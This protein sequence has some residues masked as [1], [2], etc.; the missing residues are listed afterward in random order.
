M[1]LNDTLKVKES[2]RFKDQTDELLTYFHSLTMEELSLA[3]DLKSSQLTNQVYS[4]YHSFNIR[5]HPIF[6]YQGQSFKQLDFAAY[7]DKEYA[8]VNNHLRILSALYGV[9]KPFDVIFPYR[10][11]FKTKTKFK[12]KSYWRDIINYDLSFSKVII[13]LASTEFSSLVRHEH[14]I[15]IV[16]KQLYGTTYKVTSTLAK[17]ARGMYLDWMIKEKIT[18]DRLT[19]FSQSGYL[20]CEEESDQYNLVFKTLRHN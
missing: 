10:L 8:Y 1:N 11:D 13:N 7:G 12:L 6:L 15:N 4:F 19:E 2:Y 18:I 9:L 17:Q 5:N 3:L 20:F 16:F 14:M